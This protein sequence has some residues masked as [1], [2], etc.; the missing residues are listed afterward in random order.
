MNIESVMRPSAPIQILAS[1]GAGLQLRQRKVEGSPHA[2]ALYS[3]I[4]IRMKIEPSIR[5]RNHDRTF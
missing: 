3:T 2:G 4:A 5:V 1:L